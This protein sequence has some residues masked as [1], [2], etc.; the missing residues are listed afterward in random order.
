MASSGGDG[1]HKGRNGALFG[2]VD[3]FES[4]CP[5]ARFAPAVGPLIPQL[6]FDPDVLHRACA[7]E[8]TDRFDVIFA[9]ARVAGVDGATGLRKDGRSGQE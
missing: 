9:S 2:P 5:R 8:R 7:G 6:G 1:V 4:R 3:L